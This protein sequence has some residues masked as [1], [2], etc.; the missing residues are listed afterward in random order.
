ME[1]RLLKKTDLQF[2]D[3]N[4]RIHHLLEAFSLRDIQVAN[5]LVSWLYQN[6]VTSRRF[7]DYVQMWFE[8]NQLQLKGYFD[9]VDTAEKNKYVRSLERA[10]QDLVLRRYVRN[11]RLATTPFSAPGR[12]GG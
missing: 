4:A 11:M 12:R 6:G 3:E 10:I 7:Q 1:V 5:T 8:I 2:V 9:R